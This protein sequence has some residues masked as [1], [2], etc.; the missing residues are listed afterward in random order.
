MPPRKR[1]P[2]NG[3]ALKMIGVQVAVLRTRKN[4]TQ[5]QL[6]E[7]VRLDEETIASIEQ[8]R[9]ALMPDV[10]ERMDRVLESGGVLAAAIAHLPRVDRVPAWA[11]E[12][13]RCEAEAIALS[14]YDNQVVPGLLQT[15]GYARAVFRCRVPAHTPDEVEQFTADRMARQEILRRSN[16]PTLSFVIW[17]PAVRDRLGGRDVHA[18]LLRHLLACS[19][20]PDVSLQV[21]PL[22]QTRHSA[23]DG[24]FTLLE[25]PDH[26][27]LGYTE[28]QRGSQLVSDPDEVSILARKYAMLRTQALNPEETQGLLSRLLGEL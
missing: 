17:E 26:Q 22:G 3:T 10:A 24:P 11:E 27:H 8:G 7:R 19:E 12:Y 23:L 18:E 16:P 13:M 5:R 4:L 9:R 2:R 14:W 1:V 20:L 25:T 6:G 28:S 21:M 15:E